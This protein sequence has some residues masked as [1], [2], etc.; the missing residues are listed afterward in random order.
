M[1][2]KYKT[3]EKEKAY[4]VTFTTFDWV[5]VLQDDDYKMIIVNSIRYYQQNRGLLV[6]A[7]CIMSNHVHLIIQSNGQET[8]SEVLRDLKKFTSK[9]II[10]KLEIGVNNETLLI[11]FNK[12][13]E[14]LKRIKN[15]KVWQDGN[16]AKVL[17]SNSF[18]WQKLNYI[19]NNPVKAGIV[20]NP[21]EYLYT[22]A[23]NYSDLDGLLDVILIAREVITVK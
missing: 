15:Y 2:E 4:F 21:E 17:Y 12:A 5:K 9:E 14:N 20:E 16:H 6:Y 11:K 7:Y 19:H 23:R 3:A 22:S 10:K 13:G 8:V 1:S 18:I